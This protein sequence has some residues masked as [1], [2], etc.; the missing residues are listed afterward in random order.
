MVQIRLLARQE[1]YGS[2]HERRL[3]DLL[4]NINFF[5]ATDP[6]DQIYPLP[7]LVSNTA[8]CMDMVSYQPSDNCA[9]SYRRFAQRLSEK[10]HILKILQMA[11]IFV[12]SGVAVSR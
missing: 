2:K 7:G 1:L 12:Y 5:D 4:A 6:W 10:V 9:V 3:M 8:D 11:C